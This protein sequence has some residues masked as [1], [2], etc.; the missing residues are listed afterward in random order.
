VNGGYG[1][2]TETVNV[3]NASTISG[4]GAI[5]GGQAGFNWQSGML[6]VGAEVDLQW[7][8]QIIRIRISRVLSWAIH[9]APS[10]LRMPWI[11]LV[12]GA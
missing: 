12:R 2:F 4:S 3:S 11:I 7:S 10:P 9:A 8:G 5:A 6:V 1:R